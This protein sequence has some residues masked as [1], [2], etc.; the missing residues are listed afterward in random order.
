MMSGIVD[1]LKEELTE[2]NN[3][4]DGLRQ[5]FSIIHY[6]AVD[7]EKKISD[8]EKRIIV[9]EGKISKCL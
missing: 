3:R 1:D 9:I 7:N 6:L 5:S 8:L 4:F 2:L